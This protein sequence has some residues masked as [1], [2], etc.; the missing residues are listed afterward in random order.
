MLLNEYIANPC[1]PQCSKA[2]PRGIRNPPGHPENARFGTAEPYWTKG[3]P[4]GPSRTNP[5]IPYTRSKCCPIARVALPEN[6][7]F[8]LG[9]LRRGAL[10]RPKNGCLRE[11]GWPFRAKI[12]K[13]GKGSPLVFF[14]FLEFPVFPS[15]PKQ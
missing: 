13:V 2:V 9:R 7:M 12:G 5:E 11:L 14:Q 3:L 10:K 4:D 6:G 15:T 1:L 8:K